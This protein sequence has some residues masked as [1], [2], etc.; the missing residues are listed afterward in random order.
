V[1]RIDAAAIAALSAV[2][3]EGAGYRQQAAEFDPL[4]G[5]GARRRGGRFNPPDSFPVLYLCSTRACAVAEFY[6][7]GSRLAIGAEGLLPRQLFRYRIRLDQVLDLT[8]SENMELLGVSEADLVGEDLSIARAIGE[9]AQALGM[10]AV[11]SFSATRQDDV[12]AVFLQ[13]IGSG[14]LDPSVDEVW[15]SLADVGKVP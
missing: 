11:R 7:A 10:Q 15:S 3:Y 8:V 12:F 5:E 6:R 13:N 1:A 9:S 4:N 2:S 14:V